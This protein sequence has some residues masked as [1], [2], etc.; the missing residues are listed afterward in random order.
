[1][2]RRNLLKG[3]GALALYGSF[4]GVLS[5]FA[6]SCKSKAQIVRTG[7]FADDEFALV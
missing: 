5:E 2:N 6:S 7:F 3:M 4:P 1:M